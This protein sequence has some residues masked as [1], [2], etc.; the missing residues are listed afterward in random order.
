MP[1]FDQFS[2][3]FQVEAG[4][5]IGVRKDLTR[6]RALAWSRV[7]RKEGHEARPSGTWLM[8]EASSSHENG[9]RSRRC[10]DRPTTNRNFFEIERTHPVVTRDS[11]NC[12]DTCRETQHGS[13][14]KRL[15]FAAP[16][17][18]CLC[19]RPHELLLKCHRSRDQSF[20]AT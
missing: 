16:P 7:T 18:A 6:Y 19:C 17:Q 8:R 15:R 11:T 1:T 2:Y 20:S 13:P 9:A 10:P 5:N 14:T 12:M 4:T 3:P